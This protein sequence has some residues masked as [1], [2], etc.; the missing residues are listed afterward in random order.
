MREGSLVSRI[1]QPLCIDDDDD[2][3]DY[4]DDDDDGPIGE[5]ERNS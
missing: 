2:Y 4:D 1:E 3:Y 5:P